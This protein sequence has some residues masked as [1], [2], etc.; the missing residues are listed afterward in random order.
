MDKMTDLLKIWP[1]VAFFLPTWPRNPKVNPKATPTQ[2]QSNPVA[3][4]KQ[5]R[6][7]AKATP[8][9]AHSYFF[10]FLLILKKR[11]ILLSIRVSKSVA[12]HDNLLLWI[13]YDPQQF[14]KI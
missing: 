9:Q 14:A 2:P 3:T 10:A 13:T 8:K 7:N 11:V 12:H 1:F 6:S 5:P 4:P